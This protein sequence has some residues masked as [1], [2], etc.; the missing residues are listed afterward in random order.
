[1]R[2]RITHRCEYRCTLPQ[3]YSALAL[4][5]TP[6]QENS[7]LTLNWSIQSPGRRAEQV[8]AHGNIMHLLTLE[9]PHRQVEVTAGGMVEMTPPSPL[10]PHEGGISPL[11]YLGATP[12]TRGSDA[13][14]A[15]GAEQP[16]AGAGRD[17]AL[18]LAR[19]VREHTGAVTAEELVHAFIAACRGAGVPARFVSG[20][21][22]EDEEHSCRHAWADAWNSSDSGW[23]A[24]D[25]AH[26]VPA[27]SRH[28]RLAV[29]RD[30]LDAAPVRAARPG[31]LVE[32]LRM[33]EQ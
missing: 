12:L 4:R 5:L 23:L 13:L 8:D 25:V 6:R 20:H 21:L 32:T 3:Q 14:A 9:E 10:L 1:M 2:L 7:Q 27:G 16:Q 26:L 28:C 18:R 33:R 30:W 15:L 31:E 22:M 19:A 24:L 29:G 17:A 11:A